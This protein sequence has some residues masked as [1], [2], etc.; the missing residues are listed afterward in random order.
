MV[1]FDKTGPDQEVVVRDV[2]MPFLSM[3]VFMIKWALAAIPAMLVLVFIAVVATFFFWSFVVAMFGAGSGLAEKSP[4]PA[5]SERP[6]V[7]VAPTRSTLSTLPP[8]AA[9]TEYLERNIT[10]KAVFAGEN[11]R[12]TVSNG[13]GSDLAG[14]NVTARFFD[15]QGRRI[16]AKKY[17][18]GSLPAYSSRAYPLTGVPAETQSIR[19][20]FTGG[21]LSQQKIP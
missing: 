20:D 5:T 17:V 9:P 1:D 4:S 12:A 13:G 19:L 15:A 16:E 21:T 2:K 11:S 10:Y 6:R 14:M 18:L 3:V 7:R 8:M